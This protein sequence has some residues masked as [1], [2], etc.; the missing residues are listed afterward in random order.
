[1]SF[2]PSD[3]MNADVSLGDGDVLELLF[4]MHTSA[5]GKLVA[6]KEVD[7]YFG[8]STALGA[9]YSGEWLDCLD[10]PPSPTVVL[11]ACIRPRLRLLR[12]VA[13]LPRS[14]HLLSACI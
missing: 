8:F 6:R 2:V 13:R 3:P 14:R 9:D 12:R 5:G 10:L 7:A 1:M 11:S 4:D